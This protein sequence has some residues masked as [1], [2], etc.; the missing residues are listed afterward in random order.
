MSVLADEWWPLLISDHSAT[1]P[2][3]PPKPHRPSTVSDCFARV[4]TEIHRSVPKRLPSKA[5][6]GGATKREEKWIKTNGLPV[7]LS[8]YLSIFTFKYLYLFIYIYIQAM[9]RETE[10]VLVLKHRV[11]WSG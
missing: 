3:P 5:G 11:L 9:Y 10:R 4:A 1:P 7:Y 8:I 6:P 2:P